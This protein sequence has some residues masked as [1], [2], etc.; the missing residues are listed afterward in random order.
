[1]RFRK[2]FINVY[3]NQVVIANKGIAFKLLFYLNVYV[4]IYI[5][6]TINAHLNEQN[7][8]DTKLQV[9]Y[10]VPKIVL[11]NKETYIN[12]SSGNIWYFG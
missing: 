8:F 5:I 4:F 12:T 11:P 3:H 10:L 6:F 9:L 1:M 2:R 7:I